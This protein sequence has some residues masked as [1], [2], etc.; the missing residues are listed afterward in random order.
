MLYK[1]RLHVSELEVVTCRCIPSRVRDGSRHLVSVPWRNH[2]IS[3]GCGPSTCRVSAVA[4][5][6]VEPQQERC[7]WVAAD[8]P[9]EK[10]R[11]TVSAH[12]YATAPHS[13]F[14]VS[15]L[16]SMLCH[17]CAIKRQFFEESSIITISGSVTSSCSDLCRVC[18]WP[19]L[20]SPGH[21]NH[22]ASEQ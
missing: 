9:T 15:S 17:V 21:G 5:V 19:E 20:R 18:T 3:A 12:L 7:R 14:F 10:G 16:I 6:E 22:W 11:G 1:T 8:A 2:R 4:A 13:V